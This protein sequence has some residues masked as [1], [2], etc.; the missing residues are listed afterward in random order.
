MSS[1][2]YGLALTQQEHR[3][4]YTHAVGRK[5]QDVCSGQHAVNLTHNYVP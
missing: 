5:L 1:A 3:A 4:I 2:S